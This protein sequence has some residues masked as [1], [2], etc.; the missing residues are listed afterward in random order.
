L[1][2]YQDQLA[3]EDVG[4]VI[5]V[6]DGIARIYGLD[7]VMAQELVE[8]SGGIMGIALNLEEDNVGCILLGSDEHIKEGDEVRRT[9]RIAE[10]IVGEAVFGRV[11]TPLGVPLDGKGPLDSTET[12]PL[13]VKAPGVMARQPVRE[14]LYTGLKAID[15][16]IPIGRGQRELIIGDRQIGKTALAI[17][18]IINQK[19][20]GVRCIYVAVGQKL[21][22]VRRLASTLEKYGALAHTCIV[23]AAASDPPAQLYIAPYAGATIG[24]HE[25]DNGRHALIIYDDLSKHARAYREVSLLLRRPPGREAFP[26]DV[27]YL[28]ARLLERAAKMSDELGGGSLTALPI[29]ETQEGDYSAYIPTNVISITDGQIYLELDLF[30]S[31]VRPAIG[32]GLSVSRVGGS[33]QDKM[34]RQVAGQLRSDLAAYREYEAFSQF[35][36]DLDEHTRRILARGERMVEVLKQK[37]YVP[38][39]IVEQV[40]ALFA[41]TRGHWDDLPVSAV[42][43]A[44]T[45][46]LEYVREK[47]ADLIATL[48][49]ERT[50]SDAT[51]A[52]LKDAITAYK[53]QARQL[54]NLPAAEGK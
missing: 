5:E 31:G 21:A 24:E 23:A 39:P 51:A 53:E 15:A 17:D 14:P 40:I 49:K 16:M 22:E 8:F 33:A 9:G 10:T 19:G 1:A 30:H 28:H 12:R 50:I 25:R 46:L 11:I 32:V 6:G 41:G 45:G 2:A 35:S 34:T 29:I 43:T 38:M 3:L 54:G 20:T 42:A 47:H 36:S 27:F 18:T 44:E 26:G 52:T 4:Q 37:Q 48:E 7:K 13:E